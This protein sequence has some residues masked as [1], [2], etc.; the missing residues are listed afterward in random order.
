MIAKNN[1]AHVLYACQAH[2]YL[3]EKLSHQEN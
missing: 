1:F 3:I 2:G